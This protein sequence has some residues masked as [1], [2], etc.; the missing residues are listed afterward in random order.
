[1]NLQRLVHLAVE[2][3]TEL[4]RKHPGPLAPLALL[5]DSAGGPHWQ[6]FEHNPDDPDRGIK[7]AE[8]WIQSAPIDVEAF[9]LAYHG[10]IM[11]DATLRDAIVVHAAERGQAEGGQ[12]VQAFEPESEAGPLKMLGIP[13][14]QGDIPQL[15]EKD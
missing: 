8:K 14:F 11:L 10:S 2:Q 12:Y 7:A 3:S 5:A 15:L 1:M 4:L 13:L 9:A 6:Q